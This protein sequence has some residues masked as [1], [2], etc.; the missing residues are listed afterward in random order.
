[1]TYRRRTS[2]QGP[3][4]YPPT[5]GSS[6]TRHVGVLGELLLTLAA[7]TALFLVYELW[8]TNLT[9]AHE[10]RVT[11]HAIRKSW[12]K[13]PPR[14]AKASSPPGLG[15]LHIP[16][17]GGEEIAIVEGAD[18]DRL[19]EGVAGHYN[20]P[21]SA[22]PWDSQ[23][24]FALAAHR[25]GHGARFHNL[26]RVK[27][28]DAVVVETKENWYVYQVFNTL[29]STPKENTQVIDP[30]P[31]GSGRNTPGRYITLTTCTPVLTSDYRLIVWGELE[32][33][34]AMDA[35]RTR[36]PEIALQ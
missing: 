8:W 11:A 30:I 18:P 16:A 24:N 2:P 7:V 29:G 27:R 35:H 10:S 33:I 3:H 32:R 36:P 6:F 15:F 1:M 17:L 14:T 21:P 23:G 25:D 20:Q 22:M 12:E 4:T 19:N 5:S 26:D 31:Q 34:D 28:G 9:A 13:P